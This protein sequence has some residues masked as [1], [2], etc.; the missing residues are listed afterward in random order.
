MTQLGLD[1]EDE[2]RQPKSR[3]RERR[4]RGPGCLAVVLAFAV[5]A[6]GAYFAYDRGMSILRDH[7][8]PPPDYTG[9]GSGSAV[10]EVQEGDNATDIGNTLVEQDVVKS[11]EA[12]TDAAT[13]NPAS[14]GIQVGFYEMKKQMSAESAL[15][16]LIDP[17]NMV[18][19]AVTIPEGYTVEQI[20]DTLA[21]KTDF[22]KK[23]YDKV[24]SRPAAI[25]LPAYAKGNPEG[26]LF[27]A[28]YMVPP[29]ATPKSI[30]TMMVDRWRQAA[31]EANL[32]AAAK[33]LGYTPA[34]LM[35]VA[36]LVEA[37]SNRDADR[38][39]VSRVIYNRL[40]TDATGGLLQI[41]AAVNYAHDRQ[42]GVALTLEDLE[43]DSPYNT[44]K[45]PGLPPTPIEAPGDAA[46]AAAAN[47]TDG[48]W[49]YYVTVNLRTGETK[50]T[51]DYDEFLKFKEEYKEYCRTQSD[52]C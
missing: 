42:L 35:V 17:G 6:G 29:N 20:V 18:Q 1:L 16:I 37:E 2:H 23:K 4:R 30:L 21:E 24:L 31:E 7:F 15:E 48:P 45:N 5:L 26:Y 28:T 44:Y 22:S 41:D 9:A 27:P 51:E 8:S 46:I 39:K 12:F 13:A 25:G 10:V 49:V 34:E 3:R 52:N 33:R 38:G 47:P 40:E 14:T 43:I 50:F 36:S 11:V 19:S 32:E